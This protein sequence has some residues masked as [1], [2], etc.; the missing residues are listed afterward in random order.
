VAVG[1]SDTTVIVGTTTCT[2]MGL[3]V[4]READRLP[5][6]RKGST[7]SSASISPVPGCLRRDADRRM[8]FALADSEKDSEPFPP[9]KMA[10]S[11]TFQR[12]TI[13]GRTN[14]LLPAFR[15]PHSAIRMGLRHTPHT[16]MLFFDPGTGSC[17][18][19]VTKHSCVDQ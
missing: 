19:A 17:S 9:V 14:I 7:G 8:L 16:P 15:E 18:Y 1:N 4:F 13:M 12:G 5:L 10:A 3:G 11:G 6:F 2:S